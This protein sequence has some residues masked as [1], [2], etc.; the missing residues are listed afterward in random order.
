M[1]RTLSYLMLILALTTFT[2]CGGGDGANG[3][4]TPGTEPENNEDDHHGE[5]HEV[6]EAKIGDSTVTVAFFG[7]IK[8]G[9]EA[10]LDI[11]V[12]GGEVDALRAWVGDESGTGSLKSKLDGKDG[13]YHG[14]IDTPDPIAE[15]SAIWVEIEDA[16]GKLSAASFKLP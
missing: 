2:A 14:H 8:A 3:T 15:G 4:P 9:A 13:D 1:I 7:E 5:R 6:G 10:V 12:E 11:E 16:S